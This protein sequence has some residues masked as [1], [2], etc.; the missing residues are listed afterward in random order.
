MKPKLTK[1]RLKRIRKLNADKQ[2][3]AETNQIINK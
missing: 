3:K 2:R 1:E